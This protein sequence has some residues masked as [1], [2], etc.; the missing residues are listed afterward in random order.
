MKEATTAE[1][2]WPPAGRRRP[3][4]ARWRRA[5]RS[6]SRPAGTPGSGGVADQTASPGLESMPDTVVTRPRSSGSPRRR[7]PSRQRDCRTKWLNGPPANAIPPLSVGVPAG[8]RPSS[9]CCTRTAA[10]KQEYTSASRRSC[11]GRPRWTAAARPS[12]PMAGHASSCRR[13][14]SV[15]A[16]EECSATWGNSQFSAGTPA[17]RARWL[18]RRGARMPG[19]P[20]TGWSA[21]CCRDRRAGGCAV[22]A[23]RSPPQSR[24]W[25]NAASGLPAATALKRAHSAATSSRACAAERPSAARQCVLNQRVLLDGRPYH[26]GRLFHGRHEVGRARQHLVGRG[27][28]PVGI[29]APVTSPGP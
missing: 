4:G 5:L 10:G 19:S 25:G 6:P 3:A 8:S 12:T 18:S 29:D 27:L 28:L 7:W 24:G 21:T 1:R 20:S 9:R 14:V 2:W 22:Q 15:T 13:A 23:W 11:R 17:W 26:P 16:S